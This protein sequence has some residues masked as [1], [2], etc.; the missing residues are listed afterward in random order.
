MAR[1]EV[2][3]SRSNPVVRRVRSLKGG[4]GEGI[5]LIEGIK[6]L[7]EAS[8][9]GIEVREIVASPRIDGSERGRALVDQ[10]RARGARVRFVDDDIL[11]SLSDVETSQGVL[12][13]AR[14]PSFTE[15]GFFRGDALVAI[16]VGVQNP[17]NVGALLRTAEAAG[18]T[19]AYLV[20]G[21]ADPLSWK[22]LRG[23]MGSAF[24]FPHFHGLTAEEALSRIKGRGLK[25][26]ATTRHGGLRYDEVDWAK[27]LALVL[28]SEGSGLPE[29][30]TEKA[31]IRVTIPML[32]RVESLNVSVAAGILLFEAARQRR[33]PRRI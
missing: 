13:I 15:A 20:E 19:G 27:P 10:M 21:T 17:G 14:R 18:A 5:V 31:D 7:E 24:R 8:F 11:G 1:L 30:L 16:A 28:G 32:G 33:K 2:I 12:A 25:V 29:G 4:R 6:L 9:S 22:A 23:S 26:I 3:R